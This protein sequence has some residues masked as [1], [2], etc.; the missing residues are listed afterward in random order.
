MSSSTTASSFSFTA[1][2]S[3]WPLGGLSS[4]AMT[5]CGAFDLFRALRAPRWLSPSF[6]GHLVVVPLLHARRIRGAA[7][8]AHVI[9]EPFWG[10]HQRFESNKNGLPSF[11][12]LLIMRLRFN[13][14]PPEDAVPS[15]GGLRL[16]KARWP[17]E[18]LPYSVINL[19][20][21][22]PRCTLRNEHLLPPLPRNLRR[23][24]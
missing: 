13:P 6:S 19:L 2:S 15:G 11:Q 5:R 7:S 20:S 9:S 18:R 24:K 4:S 3:S 8:Y 1:T 14:Q 22:N 21:P 17:V 23:G 16:I 12:Q 10:R